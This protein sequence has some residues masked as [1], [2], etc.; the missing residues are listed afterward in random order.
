MMTIKSKLKSEFKF[1][2]KEANKIPNKIR[3]KW[4]LD[5]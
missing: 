1:M 2:K 3:K 4:I 5:F